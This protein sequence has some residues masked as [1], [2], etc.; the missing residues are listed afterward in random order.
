M[1]LIVYSWFGM[2]VVWFSEIYTNRGGRLGL[3]W[4]VEI[5]TNRWRRPLKIAT[6]LPQ[7]AAAVVLPT[8][9]IRP[10]GFWLQLGSLWNLSCDG[11]LLSLTLVGRSQRGRLQNGKGWRSRIRCGGWDCWW[12]PKI[13]PPQHTYIRFLFQHTQTCT[14]Q[15]ILKLFWISF[16]FIVFYTLCF[17]TLSEYSKKDSCSL[18]T[19]FTTD[20]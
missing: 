2:P 11:W 5:F 14:Y 16:V 6:L 9:N 10:R 17:F 8:F 4:F 18:S 20:L 1:V 13:R 19:E 15:G 7:N 3:V 12:S